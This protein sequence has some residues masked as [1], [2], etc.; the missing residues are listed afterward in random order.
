MPRY[1]PLPSVNIDPRNE[2][3]LIQAASQ[4][5]YD[6]SNQTLNDFSTSNPLA[7]L[8]EGQAFA[9]GEFLFWANQLP[10]SILTEWVGPFLGAQRRLGT[11][12][13]AL[14]TV[15][16]PPSDFVTIIPSGATFNTDSN[17]TGG[18][19]FAFVTAGE[20]TIPVGETTASF[21]VYSQ[22]VGTQYNV[23]ANSIVI[24][25][26]SGI[27]FTSVTNLRPAV[28]GSD[29]ETYE[30]V[31]SRFFPLIRAKN[32][33]S[34]EDWSDFFTNL[35]GEGTVTSVQPNR[36][37]ERPYNY[38]TD[39]KLPNGQVSFFVL[40]PN[41]TELT[42]DQLDLGQKAV[43]FS[44][45]LANQGHLYPITLS[46]VQYNLTVEVDANGLYARDFTDTSL[47]FRNRLYTI[48]QPGNVFPPT[49]NPS[50]SDVDSAFYATFD[51]TQRYFNPKIT[52]SAAY[53]TPQ[54]F[55]TA[56]A[57]YTRVFDF[58]TS[59]FIYNVNDLVFTTEPVPA[60][61]PVI[62][63]FTPTSQ[64]ERKNT[65]PGIDNVSNLVLRQIK[66]VTAGV[67]YSQ[68]D[69]I[70]WGSGANAD[71]QLHV[72]NQN[73]TLVSLDDVERQIAL[74][75][76]S[77]AKNLIA[78]TPGNAYFNTV[79]GLFNPDLVQYVYNP[80]EYIPGKDSPI[81]LSKRPGA[82]VWLVNKNFVLQPS[83]D[84]LTGAATAG[85]LGPQ[86]ISSQLQELT[87]GTSYPAGIW[88]Y[89]P[90]IGSGPNPVA[91]PYYNYVDPTKGVVNKYAYVVTSF[92]YSVQIGQ[93]VS[94]YFDQLVAQGSLQEVSA[95]NADKGLP[96]FKYKPRFPMG[97]YLE[98]RENAV[99]DPNY[100]IAAEY[101]TPNS[102]DIN[103][104]LS[105]NLVFPLYSTGERSDFVNELNQR[106]GG[107]AITVIVDVTGYGYTNGFYYQVPTA[108]GSG[109][110]LTVDI[111][112]SNGLITSCVV[113]SG[114]TGY[115]PG[116]TFTVPT[117]I[118]GP[119]T[120]FQGTI[121]ATTEPDPTPL[122]VPT[123]MF[124]FFKGDVTY[125]REGTDIVTYVANSNVT[126]LFEL[127]VYLQN[128]IFS[129]VADFPTLS[130][131]AA[132]YIPFYN[133]AYALYAEDTVVS[134]SGR[135]YYR[136]LRPLTPRQTVINWT[137]TEVPNT[138][139]IEEY[140]GNLLRYVDFYSCEERILSQQG[141]DISAIKLGNAQITIIPSDQSSRLS[142]ANLTY[143][144][145]NT[146]SIDE[147]PGLSWFT[148]TTYTYRP[149]DYGNGTLAL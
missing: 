49:I 97:L 20:V 105:Q 118:V 87:P 69:V 31:L 91:D 125:F 15:T 50:V 16:V 147:T 38:L 94:S 12:A 53:N 124:T 86:L 47:N 39:Y 114:G 115:L 145:E 6:A 43:N 1:A 106:Y 19:S 41:G 96:L 128:G 123:R 72:I 48:L 32:P 45:P 71:S 138:A 18:E 61:Y 22:Y 93:T 36:P 78:W 28:G 44:T 85:N 14:L 25:S 117:S 46:E 55:D 108:G 98:Y 34:A 13:T 84:D 42:R 3:E 17:I 131:E 23:P 129:K 109:I 127:G 80:D 9:Q 101:F 24:S 51:N 130:Y 113:S 37:S 95:S 67:S 90:Q 68:G 63:P 75:T 64:D 60:Y 107:S 8:L 33:V 116:D 110:G 10:T 135:N 104:L 56:S 111:N 141:F 82:F 70:Y 99:S 92:T 73:I 122:Q 119:G 30:Q 132:D 102:T 121:T 65:I 149:P 59:D 26:S 146:F 54:G 21:T 66:E 89:T 100:Y 142:S 133:P 35:Y 2:A 76:I 136:V 83:T 62:V 27:A 126:P 103:S 40:G 144:W 4:R 88:V 57:T 79:D 143:V 11:T 134:A 77:P 139:R 112:V 5:V 140:E 52:A 74:G 29:V 81:P 137:Q 148:G 7:A 58:E 120:D